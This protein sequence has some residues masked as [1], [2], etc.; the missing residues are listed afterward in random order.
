MP[1]LIYDALRFF[2]RR[3]QKAGSVDSKKIGE[4]LAKETWSTAKGPAKFRVDHQLTGD[5]LAFFVKGKTASEK[6]DKYDV[7]KVLGAYG[8][9]KALPPL[10]MLGY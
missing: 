9:D 2:S 8:G 6:K 10:S 3:S 7:F 5:Y 1:C 4:V